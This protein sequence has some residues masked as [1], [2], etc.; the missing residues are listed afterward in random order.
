MVIE[1]GKETPLSINIQE[2]NIEQ[3]EQFL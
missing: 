1:K 2:K 3:V